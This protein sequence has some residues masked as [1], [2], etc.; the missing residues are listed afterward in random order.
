M[1]KA[2]VVTEGFPSIQL[3]DL[4]IN[5]RCK[6]MTCCSELLMATGGAALWFRA[7]QT[8]CVSELLRFRELGP[9]SMWLCIEHNNNR[10]TL[11][12]RATSEFKV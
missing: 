2:R 4:L 8:S 9:G 1:T 10:V 7:R 12:C 6:E 11:L 3:F 5:L